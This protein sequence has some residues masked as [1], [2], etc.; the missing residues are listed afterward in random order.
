MAIDS[1]N[2]LVSNVAAYLKRQDLSQVQIPNCIMMAEDFLEKK[3]Y[4]NARRSTL[5]LTPTGPIFQAP[6]DM[7]KPIQAYY[8]GQPLDFFPIEWGSQYAGGQIPFIAHGYQIIGNTIS[9]SVPQLGLPFQLDYYTE[10]EPLSPMNQSNWLLEDAPSIYLAA[11]LK[12]GFKYIRDYQ[13]AAIWET[14]RDNMMQSYI[15]DYM[16]NRYP[17]AQLTIRA[18]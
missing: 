8:N 5:N 14:E 15:D 6:S 1:Y 12:E 18:G 11:V 3:L 9:L 16:N 13:S 10:L 7:K 17:E 4:P 2:T